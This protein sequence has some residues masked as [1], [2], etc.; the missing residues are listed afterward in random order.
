MIMDRTNGI[1]YRSRMR[2]RKKR[3]SSYVTNTLQEGESLYVVGQV[4]WAI[5]MAPAG[6]TAI[7]TAMLWKMHL[8]IT[9]THSFSPGW[10]FVMCCPWISFVNPM[11]DYFTL[12]S[13]VTSRRVLKKL[14]LVSLDAD[15]ISIPKVETVRVS[16]GI[17]GRLYGYGTVQVFGTGGHGLDI[18][19]IRDPMRFRSVL[20]QVLA[21]RDAVR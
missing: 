8:V 21:A 19:G 11:I 7:V 15:E 10:I 6:F 1:F 13:A 12:Q 14:G 2:K 3:A 16:Q 20:Q 9:N 5:F 4:H 17:F 18:R